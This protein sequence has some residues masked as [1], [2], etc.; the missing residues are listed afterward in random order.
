MGLNHFVNDC[1]EEMLSCEVM[2]LQ[3]CVIIAS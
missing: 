3:M 2:G 1:G